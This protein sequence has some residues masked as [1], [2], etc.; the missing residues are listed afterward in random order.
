MDCFQGLPIC[1]QS[2]G[3]MIFSNTRPL[4][5]LFLGVIFTTSCFINGAARSVQVQAP[6]NV[7]AGAGTI[8]AT[9]SRYGMTLARQIFPSN[10]VAW[11]QTKLVPEVIA[12]ACD[13]IFS[14]AEIQTYMERML[15][16]YMDAWAYSE[17]AYKLQQA[18][19]TFFKEPTFAPHKTLI[20]GHKSSSWLYYK[21]C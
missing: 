9:D 12:K 11:M 3:Y 2:E 13:D 16:G 5:L 21:I 17:A 10:I 7:V 14:S 15:G 19:F 20:V 6:A 1:L 4:F 8:S 18:G